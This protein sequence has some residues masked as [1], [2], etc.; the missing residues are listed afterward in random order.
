MEPGHL[1][2]LQHVRFGAEEP[3]RAVLEKLAA[4]GGGRAYPEAAAGQMA[5]DLRQSLQRQ[6]ADEM[7]SV[8]SRPFGYAI[9]CL[10]ALSA[11][12]F[13]RRRLNG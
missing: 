13:F 9:A 11:G 6:G 1:E 12:W 4:R 5:D 8:V 2:D 10:A 7:V 3:Q